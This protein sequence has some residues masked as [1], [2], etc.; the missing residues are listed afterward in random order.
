MSSRDMTTGQIS[1]CVVHVCY[2][3]VVLVWYMFFFLDNWLIWASSSGRPGRKQ[4]HRLNRKYR[5]LDFE[6]KQIDH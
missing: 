2:R 4:G 1:I 5:I 3:S 6:V